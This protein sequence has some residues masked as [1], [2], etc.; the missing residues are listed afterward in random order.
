MSAKGSARPTVGGIWAQSPEGV[1]GKDG[2][3]PWHVPEDLRFFSI[4]TTGNPVI[5]GRR[6]WES[7]PPKFRP[8]PARPNIVVTSHPETVASDQVNVW[9]AASYAEALDLAQSLLNQPDGDI[10]AIGG[11]RIWADALAHP[12]LPLRRA[13]VTT[14]DHPSKAIPWRRNWMS[15]GAIAN[16]PTGPNRARA[17]ASAWTNTPGRE[18]SRDSVRGALDTCDSVILTTST[19]ED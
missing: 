16:W 1:I 10:W 17:P 8:L 12:E 3:I 18:S 5:M 4:T 15:P 6:T 2:T 19:L 13:Y 11:T 7:F 9:T 14:V